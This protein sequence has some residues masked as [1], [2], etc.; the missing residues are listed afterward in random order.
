MVSRMTEDQ[1][2]SLAQHAQSIDDERPRQSRQAEQD[3][4]RGRRIKDAKL[5]RAVS[6]ASTKV[7]IKV[8]G[9]LDGPACVQQLTIVAEFGPGSEMRRNTDIG[10]GSKHH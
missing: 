4:K 8:F 1:L 5:D 9:R 10:R 6:G 3:V 2:W 7:P